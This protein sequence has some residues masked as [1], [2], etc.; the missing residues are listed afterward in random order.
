ML[1]P[2]LL[3]QG[4]SSR[5]SFELVEFQAPSR[6]DPELVPLLRDVERIGVLS[7]TNIEPVKELDIEKVMGRLADATARSLGNIPEMKV[8]SQDEIRWHFNY[9]DFDSLSVFSEATRA[10]LREELE[11][12]A[13]IYMELKR[14]QAQLTPVSPTPY[15]DLAPSPGLDLKVSLQVTLINLHTNDIW[16]D[17]GEQRN[18]Q[19]VPLQLF[20]NGQAERQLLQALYNPLRQFLMRVAPPPRRQVRQFEISGD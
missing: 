4:C 2:A 9:A 15:G 18:W 1:F 17:Q 8:V 14:L 6:P 7:L 12:D 20:G 11:L 5:T 3:G 19:P 13:M 16:R 10:N